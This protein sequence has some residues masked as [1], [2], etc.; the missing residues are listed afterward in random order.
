MNLP[1]SGIEDGRTPFVKWVDGDGPRAKPAFVYVASSWRNLLQQGVVHTLRAAGMDVYDYKAPAE[2]EGGFRWSEIDPAWQG[3]SPADW[4]AALSHP[5]AQ[6]GLE[7]DRGAMA[8]ADCCVLVLPCGR[9]AHLEAGF[10][11]AEGKPVF[12]LAVDA[13]EPELMT[14]LLGPPDHICDSLIELLGLLGVED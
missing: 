5:V 13:V 1:R 14:L 4:R 6:R 11:A 3:W 9:S 2:G 10:M 12:T 8:K 7:R